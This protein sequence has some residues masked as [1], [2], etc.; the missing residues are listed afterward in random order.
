VFWYSVNMKQFPL[1]Y[2]QKIRNVKENWSVTG[3]TAI[4]SNNFYYVGDAWDSALY[5][6]R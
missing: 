3:Q 4:D 6:A 2:S 1:D 5:G